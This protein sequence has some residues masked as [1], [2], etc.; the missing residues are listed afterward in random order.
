MFCKVQ[1]QTKL[2]LN[3][4]SILIQSP[5]KV[6]VGEIHQNLHEIVRKSYGLGYFKTSEFMLYYFIRLRE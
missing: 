4:I 6:K 1:S 5:Y 2:A 3:S